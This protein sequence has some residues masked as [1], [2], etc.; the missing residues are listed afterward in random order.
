MAIDKLD[1]VVV[2][3]RG[4]LD[5]SC[6][7]VRESAAV[8]LIRNVHKIVS[9]LYSTLPASKEEVAT[10]LRRK[11]RKPLPT[12]GAAGADGRER[13]QAIEL[14]DRALADLHYLNLKLRGNPPLDKRKLLAVA[15]IARDLERILFDETRGV[16]Q[17]GHEGTESVEG[18]EDFSEDLARKHQSAKLETVSE[19]A[20]RI[21]VLVATLHMV[22][23]RA[24]MRD[25]TL[26]A[27][28][29][30]DTR[31][32][33]ELF[34]D[35]HRVQRPKLPSTKFGAL[36][37]TMA[38][39]LDLIGQMTGSVCEQM[40]SKDAAANAGALVEFLHSVGNK[41]RILIATGDRR[42]RF[43]GATSAGGAAVATSQSSAAS[44]A[45]GANAGAGDDDGDDDEFDDDLELD[46]GHDERQP[47]T[48]GGSDEPSQS[49]S[50]TNDFV[51]AASRTEVEKNG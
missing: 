32:F 51:D 14:V 42:K 25:A 27:K 29:L 39:S 26:L 1:A 10:K 33:V 24:S 19:A 21:R 48:G 44:I 31:K 9:S 30:R 7:V 20:N 23:R 12:L 49:S 38:T 34:L 41:L 36:Q 45:V 47:A 22:A 6:N 5:G 50:L 3:T 13:Q 46:D 17:L 18:T 28:G 40:T 2:E 37:T 11:P 35:Q 4:Y 15:I 43:S 8:S 16:E